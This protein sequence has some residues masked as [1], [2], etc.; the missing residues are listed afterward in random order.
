[1]L[2]PIASVSKDIRKYKLSGLLESD[3]Y[4]R[5]QV[6]GPAHAHSIQ[7]SAS[8]FTIPQFQNNPKPSVESTSDEQ[9]ARSAKHDRSGEDADVP[10][11]ARAPA[12]APP[13]LAPLVERRLDHNP[14]R[15]R[16]AQHH[17]IHRDQQGH[18]RHEGAPA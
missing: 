6:A 1:M 18:E 17:H 8:V 4:N 2:T 9:R 14:P 16:H 7:A 13:E 11:R 5:A 3:N 15:A 10:P 12:S